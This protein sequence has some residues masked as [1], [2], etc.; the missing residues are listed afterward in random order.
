M[1]EYDAI[2]GRSQTLADKVQRSRQVGDDGRSLAYRCSTVRAALWVSGT[3]CRSYLNQA[4][5][6]T[7]ICCR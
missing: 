4:E 5:N 6:L 1:N 3:I 7:S 2:N